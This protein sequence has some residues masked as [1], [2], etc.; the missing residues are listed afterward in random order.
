MTLRR[1]MLFVAFLAFGVMAT[2]AVFLMQE[3]FL[4][5]ALL[6]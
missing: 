6:T 1:R 5:A 2:S 4:P 3:Y